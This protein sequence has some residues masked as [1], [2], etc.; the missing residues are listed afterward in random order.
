M[1]F[2][3]H[4][5]EESEMK[6]IYL[7]GLLTL[8]FWAA[9]A[10]GP[11]SGIDK[12]N[13]DTSVKPQDDF[14]HY[15]N[16]TWLKNTE[17]P[18]DKSSYGSF[19][20][21]FDKSEQALREIIEA[22]AN[23][24]DKIAGSEEQKVGDFYLSF[25]DSAKIEEL[26]LQPL[27]DDLQRIQ[28]VHNKKDLISL[29]AYFQKIGV[30]RPFSFFVNQDFKKSDQYISYLSQSGLSLPDRDYYLKDSAK[31]KTIREKY[32]AYIEKLFTLAGIDD[33]AARAKRIL[34]I[35][36]EIAKKHWTRVQNRDRDK[37]YNKY[38][39]ARLKKLT[40]AF[41]W[42]AYLDAADVKNIDAVI[43]RQPDYFKAFNSI[44]KLVSVNDWKTY[45]TFK[46][47]NNFASSLPADF[48][49]ARF[50]FYG[51]TLRGIEKNRPRWKRGVGVVNGSLGEVVGK[52]YVEK[53]F[54]PEAK[55]RM[56]QLV[57]NLKVAMKERIEQLEWMTPETKK[58]AL[59]K[60]SKFHTK[61]GYPNK[62]K[63]YS[64]LA[65]EKDDLIGNLKRSSAVEYNRMIAK[66][67]KP[68]DREEWLMRPQTVNA[69]YN[70]PMNEIVF[71]AAILQPP[72]FNMT[73]DDAVNYGGIGA[74]IG[75]EISHGFDDQGR[76][77]DGDG[78]LRD[79]WT[80]EDAEKFKAR[81]QVM[82]DEY[83]SFSPVDSMHV[84]G[85][86]TLGENIAD[87]AGLTVA[88]HA[89]KNSL[90]GKEAP[91]IDG[92]TGDQRFFMGWAQVWRRKYRENELRRRLLTDPHSPS[93]YRCNGVVSNMPE[94]YAAFDVKEGDPM[95]RPED[96]RVRIW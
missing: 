24:P 89:Y 18:A 21:L 11:Q 17:I 58:Q 1:S 78:N 30:Q 44:F 10:R 86:L 38:E 13:F 4:Y 91:V 9:C 92:L 47:L 50:D 56:V 41:N 84:N 52:I 88:Y 28:D 6:S 77:S 66:L 3:T 87:L 2:Y 39:V 65:I 45:F 71:P 96:Q 57:D 31:F 26:G 36:T 67:G 64:K 33:A 53:Y 20:I 19:A 93:E 35:E 94:F 12:S 25:M 40:P 23:K 27:Q 68:I 69:Y 34:D 49:N 32:V 46:L 90:K 60:L 7:L 54:K 43:V 80:K 63:D 55:Q 82:I 73:A 95:W 81:A 8:V 16:G 42:N 14:Y 22:A 62:W 48:V 5:N 37:T 75:H 83:N 15:V 51:K 29:M 72:F 79:W 76:K 74:V 59:D 70:P 61:I 85:K